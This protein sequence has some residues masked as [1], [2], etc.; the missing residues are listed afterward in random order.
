MAARSTPLCAELCAQQMTARLKDLSASVR[1][2]LAENPT[3]LAFLLR[4]EVD[5]T[6]GLV[7]K[8]D[9]NRLATVWRESLPPQR[10]AAV[11]CIRDFFGQP[12]LVG[13]ADQ[14]PVITKRPA[15]RRKPRR[16]R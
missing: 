7:S 4:L 8:T 12:E 2:L 5:L 3:L 6:K 11:F 1:T 9:L 10:G 13:L 16:G 15:R 14:E